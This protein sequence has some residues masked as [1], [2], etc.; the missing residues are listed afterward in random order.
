MLESNICAAASETPD[1]LTAT[2]DL[3]R[4]ISDGDFPQYNLFVQALD[5]RRMHS[6]GFYPLDATKVGAHVDVMPG[7]VTTAPLPCTCMQGVC[8]LGGCKLI[9]S[10][11][12]A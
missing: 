9:Y 11:Q 7:A 5:P 3:Q 12:T 1:G 10:V 6:L 4:A 8:W 2:R